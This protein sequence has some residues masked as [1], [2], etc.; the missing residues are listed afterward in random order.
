MKVFLISVVLTVISS[1]G[2][3]VGQAAAQD[4]GGKGIMSYWYNRKRFS[5][6]IR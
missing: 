5:L 6:A 4:H 3:P 2:L 1:M